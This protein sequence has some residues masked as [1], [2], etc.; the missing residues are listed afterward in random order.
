MNEFKPSQPM[1]AEDILR[2]SVQVLQQQAEAYLKQGQ[3]E[4]ARKASEQLLK[5]QPKHGPGYKIIGDVLLRQ[6]QLEAA[7]QSYHQALKFQPDCAEVHTNIG[8]IHAKNQ[9]WEQALECY[10][11]AIAIK[12]DF[13]GAYRNLARVW[14]QLNQPQKVNQCWYKAY[15]LEPQKV[16]AEEYLQLGTALMQQNEIEEA[17]TCYRHAIQREPNLLVAHQSL[18]DALKKQGKMQEATPY[19][20]KA[21]ELNAQQNPIILNTSADT[22]AAA[23]K[24]EE[25]PPAD[26]LAAAVSSVSTGNGTATSVKQPTQPPKPE[27][28]IEKA[29]AFCAIKKWEA[30]INTCQQALKIQPNLAAAYKIQGNA[31]QMLKE[32][33]AAIRCY[34]K[35]LE[36][37]PNYP[38]VLANL[39]SI[40]AQQER[41]EKAVS[42]YQQAITQKPDFAGAYRNVAKIFT[43]MGEHQKASNCLEK[44]YELQPEKAS[45]EE[46]LK[47][48]NTRLQQGQLQ[49]AMTCYRQA[50]R[51]NPQLAEAYHGIGEIQRLQNS[52][53]SA[54]QSYRK[55]TELEPQYPRYYQSLAQLLA[56]QGK[57]QDAVEIYK[58]IIALDPNS[59][60][61]YHQIGEILTQQWR[62]DEAVAVYQKS[63]QLNPNFAA[64]YYS[65][66]KVLAKQEKWQEAGSVLHQAFQLSGDADA[67]AYRYLAEALVQAGETE[68]AVKAYQKATEL[69]PEYGEAYQKLADLLRDREQ[70]AEA[71]SAYYRAIELNPEVWWVHN[72]LADVLF[73][74]EKWQKAIESYQKA[75]EINPDFSWSHNSLAEALVKL[76]RWEEAVI[77][78]RKAIELNPEFAWSSYNLGDVLA[79]LKNWE[80]AVVA[81]R[82]AQKLQSDLPGIEEKLADALRERATI[83]LDEALKYYRQVIQQNPDHVA[84]YHKALEI[85]PDDAQ[86][87]CQ[88]ANTLARFEQLDGAIV[89]YQMAQQLEPEDTAIA[90]QLESVLKK[91]NQVNPPSPSQSENLTS[92]QKTVELL[93]DAILKY[94]HIVS[95]R[96][97]DENSYK[98][99]GQLLQKKGTIG[100]AIAAYATA[101]Q[102]S[103][104]SADLHHH[105][106]AALA[107]VQKWEEAIEEY[108]IAIN[109]YDKS[110]QIYNHLGEAQAKLKQWENAIA[111]Y[112]TAI[113][114][115]PDYANYHYNLAE[116]L[117]QT[118]KLKQAI[119]SYQKAVELNPKFRKAAKRL[120]ETQVKQA[121]ADAAYLH[122]R[123]ELSESQTDYEGCLDAV[124]S[125]FV[126]G[127]VRQKSDHSKVVFVDV[128]VGNNLIGIYPANKFRQDL[129][130]ALNSHG[131]HKF[132]LKI[133][134][135]LNSDGLVEVSVRVSETGEHLK[136]S[137]VK[138]LVGTDGK[139]HQSSQKSKVSVANQLVYRSPL[140][141]PVSTQPLVGIIILNLNG[142]KLLQNLFESFLLYNSY[143]NI[144]LIVID[145]GS[146]DNSVSVCQQWSEQ[147]PIK[148]IP[149]GENYSFSESNNLGVEQTT[150]PLLLFM[151]NDITLCQDI[152]P[153]LVDLIRDENIGI[154]GVKLLDIVSERSLAHPPTQHLGVQFNFYTQL[155]PFYPFEVRYA[156]Q[157]L[158][159]QSV[160]WRVPVVT[161]ALIMCRRQDFL[162]VGGF[163]EEYFYG[164]EDV[165][166][167]LLFGQKLGREIICA[168]HL[169]AFHH[170]GFSRF[171]GKPS[172]SF[173]KRLV[174]NKDVLEQR[175]GY[176]VRR[177]HLQDF[178]ER[179]MYWTSHPLRIGFVVTDADL[180]AAAG[181]YFTAVEL[182]EQLVREYGWEVFYLSEGP[183][184]YNL[185]QLDVVVVMRHEY[186]LR[187]IEKAK[188]TLVKIAWAR[189]WFE[190][191]AS[192]ESASDYDCFWC[193][194]QK[195]AN[196]VSQ[197]LSKSVTLVR[198]AT[199]VERFSQQA[200][201]NPELKSDY[202][203]TGS[204]WNSPREIINY[205]NP[206]NLPFEFALYGHNWEEFSQFKKSYRGAIAYS[207]LPQVYAS[208][209]IVIDDANAVTKEWG[210]TNSRVFD[211]IAAGALVVTNGKLGNEEAFDGLLPTYDS[212]ESLEEVLWNYLTDESL[213]CQRVEQ[214]QQILQEKHTYNHRAQ[215]V[216]TNL[217]EKMTLKYRIGIKIG[218]PDWKQAKEWGDYH[219]A[220]AMKRAFERQG[221]SARIDILPEWEN[222]QSYGDDVAIV[223]RGLSQYQPKSYQI[224]LMWNISHPDQVSLEEYEQ[225]DQVF[226]ASYSYAEELQQKVKVPVQPLLQ[227]TNPELFYPDD[228]E[229]QEVGEILF[230]GNS[231]KVYRK[232]VKDAVEAGL[233]VD[234]YGTNWENLLP[235][236]YLKGEHIPNELLRQYY[237][238]CGVLLNDHWETMREKGF[239]SNRLF[240]AAAC[241]SMIV[242]DGV[243]GFETVF[244]ENIHT[245][246]SVQMLSTVVSNCLQQRSENIGKRLELAKNIRENHSFEKRVDE[247]LKAIAILH[248]NKMQSF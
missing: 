67:E 86:L 101:V 28:L 190:V 241:G 104:E 105:L 73:K 36:V 240:D 85:K 244:G 41:L 96:P 186:D 48:G 56:Q 87:Y 33:S 225:Y 29:T 72:G 53:E 77:F 144:E 158:S 171:S 91:K 194:S 138:V 19:Y 117:E 181:D 201:F 230:V 49:A 24:P 60:S 149:R 107:V 187:L 103:P 239:I 92:F 204:Y 31:L 99:L 17:I 224:N 177:R 44:A 137:P 81:Y 179:G 178:F 129:A 173:Q 220:K 182:G 183:Q 233:K 227:C 184:W 160:P 64:S 217:R 78:Y 84:I 43:Q 2:K 3:L 14:T 20:R 197:K 5:I 200:E 75:I 47:L 15:I 97:K 192:S 12:P 131:C 163:N 248:K 180:E 185:H 37:Q 11:K 223:I 80:E 50:L 82:N 165:D 242:S 40:Y 79:E 32:N 207:K 191:W 236:G 115:D 176:Y 125:E 26:T 193:S 188:P 39:G 4:D 243:F 62:L 83:D 146:K 61:G 94:R 209:K 120:K 35:A 66:G 195:A 231:R 215:T 22:L 145:H 228:T 152:I 88:L 161:G 189:N 136:K 147:L 151:N 1:R 143:Q 175:F 169:A 112:Q 168:N 126:F 139:K 95:D 156:P 196:Y 116:A 216:F 211:A 45:P 170:R 123:N 206:E 7:K 237:S 9:Q 222:S 159:F 167:C 65:L 34:E 25:A 221:H 235:S 27:E 148:V 140:N 30:A 57:V 199:N 134:P 71:I 205:L 93:D 46:H 111:S 198:I 21:I 130:D 110:P 124:S 59:V 155:E 18:A 100:E 141:L 232:I 150:A 174:N 135:S 108:T 213:R 8:S 119:S 132:E 164:Y 90:Q 246:N 157:M 219:F 58:K 118:G 121:T 245:Y 55:A 98:K 106:G 218:V 142:E 52:I 42:Y 76:E 153:A 238:Q 68:K 229:N 51:L 154:I 203:F 128:F 63:I 234:V 70:F 172:E 210:S 109:F 122:R 23:Q 133:P 69:D 247:M 16:T 113:E 13:A 6:G 114:L 162:E 102:L 214:L 54:L 208:T 38:E 10:Q 166:L 226:V 127:W 202:C 89:F 212:A 74:Q